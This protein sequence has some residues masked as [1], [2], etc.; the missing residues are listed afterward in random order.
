MYPNFRFAWADVQNTYYNPQGR[1]KPFDYRFPYPDSTFDIVFAAS[2]FTHML[3]DSAA[4]YFHE[5]ARVLK[6]G[7]RALFSFF[8]LDCYRQDRP[9]PFVFGR[10]SFNFDHPYGD[11][12]D[13]FATVVPDN[14]EQMTAYRLQLVEQFAAESQLVL[15]EPLSRL[16]ASPSQVQASG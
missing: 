4:H 7:G 13:M 10:A 15:K 12:G 5:T 14:P 9:R 8:L 2:V 3:P 16:R 11:Y 6:P 1:T